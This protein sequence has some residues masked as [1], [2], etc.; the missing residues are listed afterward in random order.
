MSKDT[1]YYKNPMEF[2]PDR[3]LVDN[4]ELDPSN[5]VF[6]FGRRYFI[7]HSLLY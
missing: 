2:N 6:G 5:I 3:F 4:P 1:R 7:P